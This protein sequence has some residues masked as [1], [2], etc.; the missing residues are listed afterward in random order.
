MWLRRRTKSGLPVAT[1]T[2]LSLPFRGRRGSDLV[3]RAEAANSRANLQYQAPS[4]DAHDLRDG[5]GV[6]SGWLDGHQPHKR[7]RKR[8]CPSLSRD[9]GTGALLCSGERG[10]QAAGVEGRGMTEVLDLRTLSPGLRLKV[11]RLVLGATQGEVAR[12][13]GTDRPRISEAE[14]DR[15]TTKDRP[16]RRMQARVDEVLRQLEA[17]REIQPTP[18]GVTG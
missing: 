16:G 8:R 7:P 11:R 18:V 2:P 14:H 10:G 15:G 5:R 4:T 3:N 17:A 1:G 9:G 12:L 13:L 6:M